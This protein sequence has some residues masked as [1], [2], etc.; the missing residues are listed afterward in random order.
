MN[1]WNEQMSSGQTQPS[2]SV[3][4]LNHYT[5][6]WPDLCP[7]AI[8]FQVPFSHLLQIQQETGSASTHPINC[9]LLTLPRLILTTTA[10]LNLHKNLWS[11]T[12]MGTARPVILYPYSPG[13]RACTS[14][15]SSHG[16]PHSPSPRAPSAQPG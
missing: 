8:G 5:L 1:L 9:L 13:L 7:S 10:G 12:L 6:Q 15:P 3:S 16:P 14:R 2:Q 11:Q 4:P